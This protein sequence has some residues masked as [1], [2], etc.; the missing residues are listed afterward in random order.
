MPI[1]ERRIAML[2]RFSDHHGKMS[3]A[4]GKEIADEF[5][6]IRDAD[7][8]LQKQY[9][10]KISKAIGAAKAT[11]FIQLEEY[12]RTAINNEL[13]EVIPFVGAD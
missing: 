6:S 7:S 3:D 12:I 1:A 13:L 9:Y 4:T 2:G 11:H 8:K 5:F 10:K